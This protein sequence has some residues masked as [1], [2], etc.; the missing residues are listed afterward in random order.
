MNHCLATRL[1]LSMMLS[2]CVAFLASPASA[3]RPSQWVHQTEADFQSAELDH[4]VVT[5]LGRVELS[6]ASDQLAEL[7]AD[8]AII[9]DIAV[10]NDRTYLAIGPNG[11]LAELT[12]ENKIESLAKYEKEQIFCLAAAGSG[13]WVGVSGARSRLELMVEGEVKTTIAL[14]DVRYVWDVLSVDGKLYVATGVEG[15]V[16]V[17][18]EPQS[19]DEQPTIDIALETNQKNVLCLGVDGKN[20]VYAGTDGEGLVYRLTAKAQVGVDEKPY[21]VFVLYDAAEPEI[22]A[23]HV[24]ADG[25][26]YAGTAD[27][28]QARPGRLA[29]AVAEEKGEKETAGDEDGADKTPA[30]DDGGEDGG[31]EVPPAPEPQP[32]PDPQ[33]D[34]DG[35]ADEDGQATNNTDADPAPE[36]TETEPAAAPA[37]EPAGPVQPSRQQYNALRKVVGQRLAQLRKGL[38]VRP[39]ANANGNRGNRLS[40]RRPSGGNNGGGQAKQGNAVYR[41]G[42]DGFVR[43][44]FR[45]SVMILRI[46][47]HEGR[48][49]IATGNEG[50]VYRVDPAAEETTVIAD[51]DA[52]QIPAMSVIDDKIIIGTANPAQVAAL[53]GGYA[54]TGTFTS[55]PLDASQPSMWGQLQVLAHTPEGTTVSIETRS[56]NIGDAEAEGWSEWSEPSPIEPA[57]EGDSV[58]VKVA[59]PTARF[60]QYRL[61]LGSDGEQSPG[62]A[63]VALM[64]LVPNMKPKI[65]SLKASYP[66]PDPNAPPKSLTKMNVEWEAADPND[67]GLTYT[68]EMRKLGDD[69][70]FIELAD[71]LTGGNYEWDTTSTPDGRYKLRLTATDAKDNVPDQVQT[72]RRLSSVVLV[73]NTAPLIGG[74]EVKPGDKPGTLVVKAKVA[75]AWSIISQVRYAING[76]QDWKAVLP[77]DQIYDSTSET[78]SFTISDLS[79]G[80]TVVGVRAT[81]ALGNSRFVSAAADVPGE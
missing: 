57:T 34:S 69:Q 68:L 63:K 43:E 13:L 4:T 44:V 61:T 60:I 56:G 11:E 21:D 6:R 27:A 37:V 64:Y 51:L 58:F 31:D 26:V 19:P 3:V 49:I 62:V 67:D 45:E 7:E 81:D 42:T 66:D 33:P 24:E 41:I 29:E 28:E 65:A 12:A 55:D 14:P 32:K 59:S 25:T 79:P 9:Y 74:F 2:A 36:P 70:P 75:D 15:R 8:E 5:N 46:V 40:A 54:P 30:G 1:I 22:G 38:Q 53:G 47:E 50:Q 35:Q 72:D 76:S 23:L 17:I 78:V 80:R 20:R 48:L 52:Q 16:L 39:G 18:G 73:D 71:E 10:V 77:T